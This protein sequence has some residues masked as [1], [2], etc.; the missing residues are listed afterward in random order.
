M[1][2]KFLVFGNFGYKKNQ[3][4]GQTIKTRT[5]A[6]SLTRLDDSTVATVDVGTHGLMSLLVMIPKLFG[7]QHVMF[8]PGIK[9]LLVVAPILFLL[10]ALLGFKI[11]YVVV[12]GWLP[13]L[14]KKTYVR[15]L[16]KRFDSINCELES[17]QAILR[18]YN[19]RTYV[20]EN[21]RNETDVEAVQLHMPE[22]GTLRLVYF[23]RVMREKGIF[24]AL[25]LAERADAA[26]GGMTLDIYGQVCFKLDEDRLEFEKRIADLAGRVRYLGG[27]QPDAIRDTLAAYDVLVFPTYYA[28]EGFPGCIIDA[29]RAGLCVMCTDWKYNAEIMGK[30]DCGYVVK[31]PFVETALPL[32][33]E[34]MSRPDL[35]QRKRQA[36]L[37]GA[38]DYGDAAFERWLPKVCY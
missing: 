28:G 37:D 5:L 33:G 14:A 35:L 4:D 24:E 1:K 23:S 16:V 27:L 8:L 9:Q 38:A 32:V 2:R 10:R 20:L 18:G 36:A 17:M 6:E 12:G 7:V 19:P 29:M 30:R 3:M 13:G 26:F 25:D 31:Q 22:K 34:L 15:Q 21:Y 11:H